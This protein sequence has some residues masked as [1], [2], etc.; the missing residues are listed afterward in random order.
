MAASLLL[1]QDLPNLWGI[2][3]AHGFCHRF[4]GSC[5]C[6]RMP[7][8]IGGGS[9]SI[10]SSRGWQKLGCCLRISR[11]IITDTRSTW[12][13]TGF[14]ASQCSLH[15]YSYMPTLVPQLNVLQNRQR[16]VDYGSAKIWWFLEDKEKLIFLFM[17]EISWILFV[18]FAVAQLVEALR[19]KPAGRGFDSR[20]CQWSFFF[21]IRIIL[22]V[23]IWPWG[24]L[25]L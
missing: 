6:F 20:W 3:L 18:P 21:F 8:I 1:F 4:R 12:Y 14:C 24:R 7:L 25:S 15:L 23:A 19:Y 9:W 17:T 16:Q 10:R 22:S 2:L 13:C 11:N 5:G